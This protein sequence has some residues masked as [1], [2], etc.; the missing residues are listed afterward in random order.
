MH[1]SLFTMKIWIDAQSYEHQYL[2]R[3][4]FWFG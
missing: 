4:E 3:K 1:K 2:T